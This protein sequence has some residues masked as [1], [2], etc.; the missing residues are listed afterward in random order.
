MDD[1]ETQAEVDEDRDP[2]EV[3]RLAIM[4]VGLAINAIILWDYIKERPEMLVL[5]RRIELWWQRNV[6]N[7]EKAARALKRA[8]GE[9]VFEA[10]GVVENADGS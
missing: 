3:I 4:G 9:V 7:P 5:R 6:T 8:E 2:T 10:M 1:V